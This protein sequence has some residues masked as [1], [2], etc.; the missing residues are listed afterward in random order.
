[1]G[2]RAETKLLPSRER[3]AEV[4]IYDSV[5]GV[6]TWRINQGS[7]TA[8]KQAG[9]VSIKGHRMVRVDSTYYL[10]HRLI[11]KLVTGNDP[12]EVVDHID[13]QRDHNAWGNLREATHG[14]NRIN[15]AS[16]RSKTG[17]KG[18]SYDPSNRRYRA[19]VRYQKKTHHIGWFK[20]AEEAAVEREAAAS[21]IQ[22][23]FYRAA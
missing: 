15:S 5:T 22:G 11:W 9:T 20:T 12:A 10:A 18:V 3:L 1:M 7:M 4:F 17:F 21:E 23:E 19:V 14:Q 6:L 13:G 16:V 2:L 8:G